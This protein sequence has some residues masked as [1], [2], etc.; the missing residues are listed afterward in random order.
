MR[1][2]HFVVILSFFSF[3][4]ILLGSN[5]AHYDI[6]PRRELNFSTG[7]MFIPKDVP[8]AERVEFDDDACERVS[9]PHANILTPHETFDQD[10]FRFVGDGQALANYRVRRR[11]AIPGVA[12][13]RGA[14]R[15]HF[16]LDG[17]PQP[18]L[19]AS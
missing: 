5:F 14:A 7:W 6:S 8:G 9:V 2:L 15:I 19:L 10:M 13:R 17:L 11:P 12:G 18:D 1:R 16:A 4:Q 3:S